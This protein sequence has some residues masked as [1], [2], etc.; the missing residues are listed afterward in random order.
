MPGFSFPYTKKLFRKKPAKYALLSTKQLSS[1]TYFSVENLYT[2][3][4]SYLSPAFNTEVW[5]DGW[6]QASG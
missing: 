2:V 5:K 3:T 4:V 1:I 6:L